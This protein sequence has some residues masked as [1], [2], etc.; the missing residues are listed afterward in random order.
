MTRQLRWHEIRRRRK[1]G[2]G[3]NSFPPTPFPSRPARAVWFSA[4]RS[5]AIIPDFAQKRF[6]RRSVIATNQDIL[7]IEGHLI[8]R[9]PR[10]FH[11]F[12][13]REW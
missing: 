4:A 11:S 13:E 5:A 9:S 2:R 3:G 8:A 1:R 6:E 10:L 7:K 12:N